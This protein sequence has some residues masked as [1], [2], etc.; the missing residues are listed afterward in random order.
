MF[1]LDIFPLKPSSI[2]NV[3]FFLLV[4]DDRIN[5]RGCTGAVVTPGSLLFLFATVLANEGAILIEL[6]IHAPAIVSQAV[7]TSKGLDVT[8]EGR[9]AASEWFLIIVTG[10]K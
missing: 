9:L 5:R 7:I 10:W 1:F 3:V 2:E 8:I 6:D 4:W